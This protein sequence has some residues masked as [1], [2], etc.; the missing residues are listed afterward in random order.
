MLQNSTAAKNI[1]GL[2]LGLIIMFTPAKRLKP[3][4]IRR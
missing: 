1:Q 4:A 2:L 3:V